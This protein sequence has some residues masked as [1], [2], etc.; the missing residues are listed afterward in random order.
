MGPRDCREYPSASYRP[1]KRVAVAPGDIELT[2]LLTEVP[3]RS[4][5]D[6]LPVT[7]TKSPFVPALCD[8]EF[9]HSHSLTRLSMIEDECLK[10]ESVEDWYRVEKANAGYALVPL[11]DTGIQTRFEFEESFAI[12]DVR[13]FEVIG[14]LSSHELLTPLTIVL[15][16]VSTL[17]CVKNKEY[18]TAV[19]QDRVTVQYKFENDSLAV[20]HLGSGSLNLLSNSEFMRAVTAGKVVVQTA[21]SFAAVANLYWNGTWGILWLMIAIFVMDCGFPAS[22]AKVRQPIQERVTRGP[23]YTDVTVIEPADAD[24]TGYPIPSIPEVT[25]AG[26]RQEVTVKPNMRADELVAADRDVSFPIS[27]DGVVDEE[28]LEFFVEHGFTEEMAEIQTHMVKGEN[29]VPE[30]LPSIKS[31]NGEWFLLP[32]RVS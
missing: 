14:N 16:R 20:E 22:M 7:S 11:N 6:N 4:C 25:N 13:E 21:L 29:A 2:S 5:R 9:E 32:E 10:V 15:D 12:A 17:S 8:E 28:A 24:F 31:H 23:R 1:N 30:R 18:H 27:A 19:E 26:Q 3:N